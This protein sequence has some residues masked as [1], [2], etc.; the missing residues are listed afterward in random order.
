M[1]MPKVRFS[2]RPW[3]IED[4]KWRLGLFC[5][6]DA[7][8][9]S[10]GRL[11]AW[12][13]A[14]SL[15]GVVG[16]MTVL[17]VVGYFAGAGV[18]W[19]WLDRRPYN[20][21]TYA[22]LVWPPRWSQLQ[23]KRGQT[24]ITA[25]LEDFKNSKWREGE[26]ALR[27]GLSRDP[28]SLPA[29]LEL[30]RFYVAINQRIR[31]K[32]VLTAGLDYGYPGSDYFQ[33]MCALAADGEDYDWWLSTC[34][35]VLAQLS[36][37]P[38]TTVERKDAI[39]QKMA[40]LMAANRPEEVIRLVEA[41]QG[42]GRSGMFDEFKVLALLKI[43][44]PVD[45]VAFLDDWRKRDGAVSQVLRLQVRAYREAGRLAD[46]DKAI[47]ELCAYSPA[48][49]QP[50]IYGIIQNLLA[51]RRAEA[52]RGLDDF[53]LRF[54]STP[55]VLVTLADPLS[56]IKEQPMLERLVGYARQQ[57]FDPEP[58]QR[59]LFRVLMDKG[60]WLRA[61][62]FLADIRSGGRDLP[63]TLDFWYGL[64]ERL[65]NAVIDPA[66][67]TQSALTDFIRNRRVPLKMD[68]DLIE[69]LRRAGRPE[70][71]RGVITF[72]QGVYPESTVLKTW[73]DELDKELAS[74]QTPQPVMV[75]P[76]V[77]VAVPPP[78]VRVPS[79][80]PV[81]LQQDAFFARLGELKKAGDFAGALK[82]I[83]DMREARPDWLGSREDEIEVEEILLNGRVGDLPALHLAAGFYLNG[84]AK[85]SRRTAEL[86]REL[87][88]AGCTEAAILLAK[89]LLRKVPDYPTAKRLLAEW[90]P[91][92]RV[93]KP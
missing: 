22:D 23:Q 6:Y 77:S 39:L 7:R 62:A 90:E 74:V 85:H 56:E 68:K 16:W 36:T 14:I 44:K 30:S 31:A 24:L 58:I 12:R 47:V 66:G 4:A 18:L 70:T 60:D 26:M 55:A 64:M 76:K 53:L 13:L 28:S 69:K 80:A 46:M 41:Q 11:R 78:M 9:K 34:D 73:L 35:K 38:A 32:A 15:R 5:L 20:Q 57:G 48:T 51:G 49:P 42:P 17:L 1:M 67:G 8:A 2:W 59:S 43:G 63:P 37:K 61:R 82:Q 33:Q 91:K 54:G 71:A 19:K 92:A 45:A 21:V 89:D 3:I 27:I 83:Q 65:C 88:D 93:P 79:P 87:H 84:D 86:A 40:A 52:E 81:P 10:A 29:R 25:G 50:Y 72:A 75:L